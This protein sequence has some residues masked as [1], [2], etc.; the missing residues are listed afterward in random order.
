M[1]LI[2]FKGKTKYG[3]R[4]GWKEYGKWNVPPY[5]YDV[6]FYLLGSFCPEEGDSVFRRNASTKL[7]GITSQKTVIL[8]PCYG[9]VIF[10][11]RETA[12]SAET[13]LP[14]YMA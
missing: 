10:L 5:R 13:H 8:T 6:M 2:F 7:Y 14:N 3:N 9:Y 4:G 11:K 1:G 12:S